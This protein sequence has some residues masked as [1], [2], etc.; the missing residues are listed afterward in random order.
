MEAVAKLNNCPTSP[1]KMRLVVDL[2]RGEKVEKALYI[3]KY[4]P[5]E[6]S[7]RVAF[8]PSCGID[9]SLAAAT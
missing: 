6:A 9:G 1:R 5:K 7:K 3:L 4:N 8:A 2:I